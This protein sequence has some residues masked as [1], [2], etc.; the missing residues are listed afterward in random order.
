MGLA[1]MKN[2][3]QIVIVYNHAA[4]N[5]A[6]TATNGMTLQLEVGNQVYMRL[7]TNTWIFD[8]V[9]CHSTFTGFLLFCL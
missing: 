8:N 4:G 9:H 3:V 2:G 1:L 7:L 5:R 6:E